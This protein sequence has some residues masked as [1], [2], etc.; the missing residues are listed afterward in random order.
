MLLLPDITERHQSSEEHLL[1]RTLA[2][3]RP[4][5][6][7]LFKGLGMSERKILE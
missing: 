6:L 7:Q 4:S 2:I 3:I 1:E 5:A